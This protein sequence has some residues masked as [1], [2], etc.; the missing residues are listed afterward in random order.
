MTFA[1]ISRRIAAAWFR[2]QDWARWCEIDPDF[3][4]DYR[5]WLK[6]MEKTIAQYQAAGIPVIKT[7][8]L[9]DEFLEWSKA[10]GKGVGTMARA[11]YAAHKAMEK[12]R[13]RSA[14][15]GLE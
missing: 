3:Q 4:P 6:R 7:L 13:W 1:P 8:V 14:P 2:R 9:P 10:N 12:T 11:H 5:H 15:D